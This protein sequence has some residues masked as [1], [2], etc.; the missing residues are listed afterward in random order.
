MNISEKE[1]SKLKQLDCIE[2]RQKYE[3]LEEKNKGSAVLSFMFDMF[4]ILGFLMICFLILYAGNKI[5]MAR[6]F[7][8]IILMVTQVMAVGLIIC[9]FVDIVS[10]YLHSKHKKELFGEYFKVEPKKTKEDKK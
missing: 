10:S 7:I 8:N 1:L 4:A 9:I 2:F 3:I 5:E 6:S